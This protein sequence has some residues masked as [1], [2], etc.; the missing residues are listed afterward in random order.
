MLRFTTSP[1]CSSFA[2]VLSDLG[3]VN[4]FLLRKISAH[5]DA[6]WGLAAHRNGEHFITAAA[7]RKA[8][9]WKVGQGPQN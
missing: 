4:P 6:I 9:L 8:L 1:P 2:D 7:D 5:R 3:V